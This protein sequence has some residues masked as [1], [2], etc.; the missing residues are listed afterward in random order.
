MMPMTTSSSTRVKPWVKLRPS[1]ERFPGGLTIIL[2]IRRSCQRMMNL[3][4]AT[5]GSVNLNQNPPS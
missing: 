3:R 1:R 2:E 5:T 4:G